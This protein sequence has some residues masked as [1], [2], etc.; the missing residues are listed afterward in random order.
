MIAIVVSRADGASEHVGDHL[1]D[2]HE[3]TE[4]EDGSRPDA[5]G[6]GA[7][8]RTEGFSLRTFDD[9]HIY[10]DRPAA[11]FDDPDYLV[12]ASRHSGETGALLTAHF[13]GNFG[14]AEFGGDDG[15]FAR[16][17]PN[18]QSAVVDAL[19]AHA[20]EAYDV[21]IECTHHG[22]TDVGAP[23]MFVELGSGEPQWADAEA[24]RAVARAILDLDGVAPTCDRQ[25]VGFGGGHYAPRFTRVV[26]ETAWSVG[27]VAADW[28]LDA[29]GD[30]EP[31]RDVLGRAVDA[32]DAD[33][34]LVEESSPALEAALDDVG[35]RAVSETWVRETD[36][37]PL[38]V[39]ESVEADLSSVDDGLRFGDAARTDGDTNGT[40]GYAVVSL[41]DAL[42][43]EAAGIDA[44]ATRD[45]VRAHTLAFETTEGGTRPV[46]RA[47]VATESDRES[48][49][50]AL[51]DVLREKYDAVERT[52]DELVV[53]QVGFDPEKARKLGVDEGPAFGRLAA[54]EAVEVGG[55]RIPPEA[56]RSERVSRFPV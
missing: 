42:L 2:L 13:T 54:G 48:L 46:G 9:L 25:L 12:F 35:V 32:S 38:P 55:E 14:P 1:L 10:L 39:V 21:A 52:G 16:A 17:C 3:W 40:D 19:A 29:M 41:P 43:A 6:G 26:R 45:A 7:Y 44:D 5:E 11:A 8:Y 56:V 30:P 31:N 22:P 49:I 23:S 27:H 53:R 34:A 47:A 28:C 15:A 20:P 50:D 24:A 4:H 18:A 36:G 33:Y 37:V 51:V